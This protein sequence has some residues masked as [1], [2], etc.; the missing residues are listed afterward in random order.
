MS[1]I[2]LTA[3]TFLLVELTGRAG[4]FAALFGFVCALTLVGEILFN[5][6][7][8][9]VLVGVDGKDGVVEHCFAAG[10]FSFYVVDCEFH[11]FSIIT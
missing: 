5:I 6:E 1:P 10:V 4:N 7:I 11:Y 8:N 3:A 9:G 2:R